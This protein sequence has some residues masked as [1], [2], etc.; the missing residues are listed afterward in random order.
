MIRQSRSEA[1]FLSLPSPP[2][3]KAATRDDQAGQA[4]TGDGARD[5]FSDSLLAG[6]RRSL[7]RHKRPI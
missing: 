7:S 4:S 6:S 2:S 3:K 5:R 1:S